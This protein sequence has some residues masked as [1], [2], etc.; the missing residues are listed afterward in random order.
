MPSIFI[1]YRRS[2]TND[3]TRLLYGK[4]IEAFGED[5]IFR[6]KDKIEKG[7]DFRA[8]IEEWIVR[9]DIVVVVI[10]AG[11]LNATNA[12]GRRLDDPADAVRQEVEMAL[13]HDKKIIPLLIDGAPMPQANE[14][15]PSLYNLSFKN[16]EF[17]RSDA[18][19]DADTARLVNAIKGYFPQ[20]VV[21]PVRRQFP[22]TLAVGGAAGAIVV[23]AIIV[24]LFNQ[25]NFLG[26]SLTP[27]PE[28]Q[29][30]Q[31]ALDLTRAVFAYLTQTATYQVDSIMTEIK[32][33]EDANATA[34]VDAYTDT[35]TATPTPTQTFTP[36]H[37]PAPTNDFMATMRVTAA[38][39]LATS[40]A[41]T[42]AAQLTAN[43]PTNTSLPLP[44]ETPAPTELQRPTLPSIWTPPPASATPTPTPPSSAEVTQTQ[45]AE[46]TRI[47]EA[48]LATLAAQGTS[49]VAIGE[50]AFTSNQRG[51]YDIYIINTDGSNMRRL[52]ESAADETYPAWSPDGTQIAFVSDEGGNKE[53][54][55]M[56]ADG[57]GSRRLTDN[58]AN[59]ESP[60]WSPDGTKIAFSSNRDEIIP[61]IYVMNAD[62]SD[63]RRLTYDAAYNL[64]P[65]WS[66]DGRE[67]AFVFREDGNP[68]IYMMNA[69]GGNVRRLTEHQDTD[70]SPAW[71][72][73]GRS[74]AFSS[75]RDLPG[76]IYT[77]NPNGGDLKQITQYGGYD[78]TWS[79]DGQH[80]AYIYNTFPN[81]VISV[82]NADG[83]DHRRITSDNIRAYDP[84]WRP[85]GGFDASVT[86]V[87]GSVNTGVNLRARPSPNAPITGSAAA[88]TSFRLIGRYEGWYQVATGQWIFAPL[89]EIQEGDP[90]TLPL[91][92]P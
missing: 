74:I 61:E 3:F 1:S 86:T 70:D 21:T 77:M 55:V 60:A 67:I 35:P 54:Y 73:D 71:S 34:T 31:V 58:V 57:S 39:A 69:D 6:D 41:A 87:M 59:D 5:H 28:N 91:V 33:N 62:G 43:V 40:D 52:T 72:P 64:D 44:T 63:M 24:A 85:V 51:N 15:P 23:L 13:R 9:S 14:L 84:A 16:A 27:T 37:T 18:N 92:E 50:I 82:M 42:S 25:A 81:D 79:P 48:A 8:A 68:E 10:G 38:V 90:Q 75:R 47:Y 12:N 83:S 22:I 19:F 11:W 36:T 17:V 20:S 30:T 76:H 46:Q 32:R 89:V 4:L 7:R 53:I 88:D 49:A 45:Q 26:S 78:P 56:N 2:D 66:R 65:A 80:I 29:R